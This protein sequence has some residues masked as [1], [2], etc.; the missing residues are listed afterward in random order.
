MASNLIIQ[1]DTIQQMR[2]CDRLFEIVFGDPPF[3][4]DEQYDG[5]VDRFT[6]EQYEAFTRDWLAAGWERVAPGGV[7]IMHGSIKLR[8]HFWKAVFSNKL[9][10][11]YDT[12]IVW[13]YRFGQ[14]VDTNWIGMHCPWIILRKP[15]SGPRNWYPDSVLVES[16]RKSKYKDPRIQQ[17]SRSGYRVPGTVWYGDFL[18]RIQ[19]GN[20]ER[21]KDHPNQLPQLMLA[22]AVHA[23]T[24]PGDAVLDCFSGS[25]TMSVVCKALGRD[26]VAYDISL[27]NVQS[28][29]LR[30][31][32]GFVRPE[33]L[34]MSER[35]A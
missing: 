8:P 18:G 32:Q 6:E 17:S 5:F 31:E 2:G 7:L 30:M 26:S 15:C 16:D 27:A 35:H 11:F 21:W 20:K 22:R 10:D 29:K 13:H 28:G 1:G 24:A 25:G 33:I 19:G 23:Y 3:N 12:E 34:Q 4:Q 14:C 9:E